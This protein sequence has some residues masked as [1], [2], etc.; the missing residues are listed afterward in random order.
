MIPGIIEGLTALAGTILGYAIR[1]YQN[2][3]APFFQVYKIQGDSIAGWEKSDV[4]ENLRRDLAGSFY[5]KDLEPQERVFELYKCWDRADDIKKFW[6]A[7]EPLL[8]RV[9]SSPSEA[10]LEEAVFRLCESNWFDEWF[11]RLLSRSQLRFESSPSSLPHKINVIL[12]VKDKDKNGVL[13]ISTAYGTTSFGQQM[14]NPAM[15][16]RFE[17]FIENLKKLDA[18]RLKKTLNEFK[19]VLEREYQISLKVTD[20]LKKL[21][22]SSS[23]WMFFI[24]FTNLSTNPAVIEQSVEVNVTDTRTAT[25]YPIECQ[26]ARVVTDADGKQSVKHSSAPLSLRSGETIEFA[27]VSRTPQREMKLG[28]D[29]RMVFDRASGTCEVLLHLQRPGLLRKQSARSTRIPFKR[30]DS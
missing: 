12:D 13:W 17:V 29:I 22:D 18:E 15:R 4:P 24:A 8:L 19:V 1:E 3:I 2:Q 14:N 7:V 27:V 23:R 25:N 10:D 6:P 9:L 20:H 11:T 26:L 30:S 16:Q 5:I 28:D 21:I